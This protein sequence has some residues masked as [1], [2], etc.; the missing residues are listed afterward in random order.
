MV[1]IVITSIIQGPPGPYVG[2]TFHGTEASARDSYQKSVE[3][4][5]DDAFTV[6]LIKLDTTTLE[7]TTLEHTVGG[8]FSIGGFDTG[9]DNDDVPSHT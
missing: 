8:V 2:T 9:S 1:F 4:L 3:D 6:V 7:E 5:S